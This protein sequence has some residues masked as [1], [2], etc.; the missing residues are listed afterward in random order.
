VRVMKMN[1]FPYYSLDVAVAFP[2]V[3]LKD[4]IIAFVCV[5]LRPWT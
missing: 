2:L 5:F 4:S 3:S 1:V